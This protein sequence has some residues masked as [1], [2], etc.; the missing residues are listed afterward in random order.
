[1]A[2]KFTHAQGG[3]SQVNIPPTGLVVGRLGGGAD[4]E[5]SADTHMSRRHGRLWREGD[6]VW[7]E[8]LGSSNGSWCDGARLAGPVKLTPGVS[9]RLGSTTLSLTLDDD[10]PAQ[11]VEAPRMT[12]M[13]DE[14]AAGEVGSLTQE[15]QMGL[16]MMALYDFVQGLLGSTREELISMTL[17]R[18][19][20][21]VPAAQRI[22]L[23]AWPPDPDQGWRPLLEDS[24]EAPEGPISQ[25]MASYAVEKRRALLLSEA[26][27]DPKIEVSAALHGI[28]S[29]VYVPLFTREDEPFGLLCVDTP[30]ASVPFTPGDF[31]L[32][33][34]A[35]G[36]L[37]TALAS[38]RLRE[39]ARQKELEA[40]QLAARREAMVAFLRIA[41]HDLKNPLTAIHLGAEMIRR[42]KTLEQAVKAAEGIMDSG[43]RA[44]MLI[45][46]YLQVTELEGE[47]QLHVN[48]QSLD[49]AALLEEEF[50]FI[51]R[52]VDLESKFRFEAELEVTEVWADPEK[53][54]QV[55]TNLL[56]NAVKYSPKGGLVRVGARMVEEDLRIDVSDQGVGMSEE[57]QKR[58]F[59]PF[60]RL[61]DVKLAT[62]TGLGLWLTRALVEAHGG[63]IW[64]ESS[65]GQGTTF[66]F[67][68]PQ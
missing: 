49:L 14:S 26:R 22:S 67:Q 40:E 53:L 41:S 11:P 21:V 24:G 31:R 10:P 3:E 46:N 8:D 66:S 65:P 37:A 45:R 28:R 30:A 39:M 27:V 17:K 7:Y 23:V 48:W 55:L 52:A 38:E 5:L 6:E 29:A 19:H 16:Y 25:S 35:G 54:R 32:I 2:V 15:E 43:R 64:V 68:F 4:L 63:K 56:S 51:A 44:Q 61:G 33:R 58:L 36:L 9:L 13:L 42:V 1:M 62:G 18:L 60:E 50:A 57:D 34:A 47:H 59:K 20:E 12:I